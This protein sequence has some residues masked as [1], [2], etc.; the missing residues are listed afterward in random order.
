MTDGEKIAKAAAEMAGHAAY[1]R[2]ENKRPRSRLRHAPDGLRRRCRI[3]KKKTVSGL[4][5]TAM[6]GTCITAKN[7]S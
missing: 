3:V 4:N 6:S 2:C 5:H 7:G 1:Q